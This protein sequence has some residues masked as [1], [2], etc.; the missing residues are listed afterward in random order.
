MPHILEISLGRL[1]RGC[2]HRQRFM[3]TTLK[4]PALV[5]FIGTWYLNE[6]ELTSVPE[7]VGPRSTVKRT[8]RR[9][10]WKDAL[11]SHIYLSFLFKYVIK[12][13]FRNSGP[14]SHL[15]K[16]ETKGPRF[17]MKFLK[18]INFTKTWKKHFPAFE[19]LASATKN[20]RIILQFGENIGFDRKMK[21][22]KW[23]T[24][25]SFCYDGNEKTK[26]SI[27]LSWMPVSWRSVQF[28]KYFSLEEKS[29]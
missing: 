16:F 11:V 8:A 25:Y 1:D 26:K 12:V 10:K 18:K 2:C 27:F 15:F 24:T 9:S 21:K 19:I 6:K 13:D 28:R 3:S 7:N 23:K 5:T 14:V 22:S 20:R 4:R 17:F 29:R